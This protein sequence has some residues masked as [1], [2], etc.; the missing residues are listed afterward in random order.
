MGKSRSFFRLSGLFEC[1]YSYLI[2]DLKK[3][4]KAFILDI[5][6]GGALMASKEFIR[7][8]KNIEIYLSKSPGPFIIKAQVLKSERHWYVSDTS[9]ETY[10]TNNL[11]FIDIPSETRA[12][13]IQYIYK[14][15][16]DINQAK[17]KHLAK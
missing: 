14:C 11:R 17:L 3:E 5:S 16:A 2:G 1:Q 8:G 12:Q 9:K 13:I 6:A 10:W 4:A 15:K 7:H